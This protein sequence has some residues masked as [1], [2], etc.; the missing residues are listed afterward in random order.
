MSLQPSRRALL[1]AAC[2]LCLFVL[3]PVSDAAAVVMTKKGA[4]GQLYLWQSGSC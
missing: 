1:V 2:L 3:L 4:S